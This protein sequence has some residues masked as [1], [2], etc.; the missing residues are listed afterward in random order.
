MHPRRLHGTGIL[1]GL[2]L[3]GLSTGWFHPVLANPRTMP[4]SNTYPNPG[5]FTEALKE[6]AR[7]D[8]AKR[9]ASAGPEAVPADLPVRDR[10]SHDELAKALKDSQ[11]NNP[12][13]GLPA[14][15]GDGKD[16]A[17]AATPPDLL[18]NSDIL[19]HHGKATLVPKRAILFV[20]DNYSN[21]LKFE[22]G[23]KIQTFAEFLRT[24]RDWIKTVEVSRVQ[25]EGGEPLSEDTQQDLEKSTSLVVATYQ[26]GP[27]SVLPP[28]VPVAP[29]IDGEAESSDSNDK[30]K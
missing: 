12:M 29:T 28:Q 4:P 13:R 11:K 16:P 21:R 24:N 22:K 7:A 18:S 3:C 30:A 2:I 9:G 17:K 14:P 5:A 8:A 15:R 25:A 27:I 6:V 1:T 26:G 23:A 20:P 19:C 10:P